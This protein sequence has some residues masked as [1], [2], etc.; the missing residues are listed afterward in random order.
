MSR[1]AIESFVDEIR[2]DL[3]RLRRAFAIM[4][5][6]PDDH[7]ALRMDVRLDRHGRVLAQPVR[8]QD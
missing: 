8:G 5:A 3:P 1:E 6:W 2:D 4:H 7:D